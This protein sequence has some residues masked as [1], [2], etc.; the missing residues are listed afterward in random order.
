[1]FTRAP[2]FRSPAWTR[3]AAVLAILLTGCMGID[4]HSVQRS[5]AASPGAAT[6]QAVATGR[7]LHVV[8]GRPM[9]YGLLDK[10]HLSLYHHQRRVLM[11][12]P[13]TAADGRYRWQLPAG[14]YTVAVIFGGMS[15]ARQALRLPSGSVIRV[16]GIVDPGVTFTLAAGSVVDLGTLVVEVESTPARDVL[17]DSPVF[18]RLRGLRV[19]PRA[20]TPPADAGPAPVS[21]P[22]QITGRDAPTAT[23]AGSPMQ[24]AVL[25]PVLPLLLR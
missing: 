3:A 14:D 5:D 11:S 8:D 12:S 13:E 6:E 23:A 18:G 4:I 24:P 17:F 7:I 20:G 9:A 22:M 10:P 25:A 19:E 21:S 16:N 1:M 2:L 15:P